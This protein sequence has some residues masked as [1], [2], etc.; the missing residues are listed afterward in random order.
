MDLRVLSY[1]LVVAREEN[2]TRAATQLHVTQPTLSRQLMQLEEELGVKLFERSSHNIILTQEGIFLRRRAQELVSL[3]ERTKQELNGEN[4]IISGR[5]TIGG[6]EFKSSRDLAQAVTGFVKEYEQV[7][8]DIYSGNNDNIVEQMDKGLID[9][10][11]FLAPIDISKYDFIRMPQ[12]EVWG[13]FVKTDSPLAKKKSIKKEELVGLNLIAPNRELVQTVLPEWLGDVKEQLSIKVTYNLLYNV[14]AM[15]EQ[16]IDAA[17]C[18]DLNA[19]YD[20][21]KFIPLEPMLTHSTVLAWKKNQVL[22][23]AVSVFV[24]FLRESADTPKSEL[25]T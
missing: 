14:T 7:T 6:G 12:Q 20:N 2:I 10:G 17:L 8:F 25:N 13:V 11:L 9:I 22:S 19:K 5:I 21:L 23:P 18:L 15:I 1:F 24:K 3:A 16:G 4:E